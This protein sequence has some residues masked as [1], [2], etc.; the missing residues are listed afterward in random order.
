MTTNITYHG[1]E[2]TAAITAY[3]EE[4]MQG[5]T[6]YFEGIKHMDIGISAIHHQG[7]VFKCKVVV[8]TLKEVI[9]IEKEEEDLYKAIDKVKDHVQMELT[10]LKG[11]IQ[12]HQHG[13]GI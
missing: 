13:E 11:Q 9:R 7:D 10:S 5:L 12:D 1:I 2:P 4:K 8:E 3:V 6:K